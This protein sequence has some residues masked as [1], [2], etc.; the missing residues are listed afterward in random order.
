MVTANKYK[1]I[2][3]SADKTSLLEL[4]QLNESIIEEFENMISKTEDTKERL[5]M[6]QLCGVWYN[7]AKIHLPLIDAEITNRFS[8]SQNDKQ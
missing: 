5:I 4:K 2:L 1:S 8:T 3:S 6:S 7:N